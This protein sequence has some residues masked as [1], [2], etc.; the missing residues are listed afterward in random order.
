LLL[1]GFISNSY[2]SEAKSYSLPLAS[3]SGFG[4]NPLGHL[5]LHPAEKQKF[6]LRTP[7]IVFL[8]Q[9]HIEGK[10]L[11]SYV[12]KL[13]KKHITLSPEFTAKPTW[14]HFS[15]GCVY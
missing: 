13:Y 8:H 3:A 14:I 4:V 7:E 15:S 10:Y 6:V 11:R 1:Q 12:K 9:E 2:Q 5:P